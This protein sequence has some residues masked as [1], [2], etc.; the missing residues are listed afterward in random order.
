MLKVYMGGWMVS[1]VQQRDGSWCRTPYADGVDT[2][3]LGPIKGG[4]ASRCVVHVVT[5]VS[6]MVCV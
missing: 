6:V 4:H 5:A 1:V 3:P 2:S